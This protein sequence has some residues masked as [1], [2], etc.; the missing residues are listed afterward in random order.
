M[1]VSLF[2]AGALQRAL[3]AL[4]FAA[5]TVALTWPTALRPGAAVLG[6]ESADGMKHLWTLWW[7]RASVW[8]EGRFPFDTTLVN[9]P[10]GMGLY[11]IEPLNGIFAVLLPNV[12]IVL[13]SNLLVMVN[14]FATGMVGAWFGRVLTDG[15][16]WSGLA[17]GTVLLCSS[18]TTFFVA[19]GV[20]E[21]THLWWLPL[22]FGFLVRAVRGRAWKD[23]IILASVMVGAV[24]SCFYLGFFLAV[25]TILVCVWHLAVG[26]ER[27]DLLVRCATAGLLVLVITVP[28]GQTFAHSYARP[29]VQSGPPLEHV[30]VERGQQITDSLRSRL[31]PT[32]LW[33]PRRQA[34]DRHEI[35]YG[36]GRYLGILVSLLALIGVIRR[37]REALPWVIV[38]GVGILMALGSYLTI[39]GLEVAT[40]TGARIRLP[41]LWLNRLL[42]LVAEPVNFPVRFLAL[43]VMA[44]SALVALA[45][46]RWLALLIPLA[47]LEIAWAQMIPWPWP[48]FTLPDTSALAPLAK[49]PGRSV[50]DVTL[51]MQADASNRQLSLAGQMTHQHPT[52]VVPLERIEYFARDGYNHIRAM[53]LMH[54]I[55]GVYY[56][57]RMD[58]LTGEYRDD[59][60]MLD[61]LGYDYLLFATQRGSR[62]V[63][64]RARAA[65]NRLC[66][67][68]VVDGPGGVVW[69]VPPL[70]RR[71]LPK[72]ME[73]WRDTHLDRVQH[74]AKTGQQ[75]APAP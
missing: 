21:L 73:I 7:I 27:K 15:N 42:E 2:R 65:L 30:F 67:N 23:W 32:Q 1:A 18:V 70:R 35:G 28:I 14:L 44:Q 13:L 5:C 57:N 40:G 31:D 53:T 50:V 63:P 26:A 37:P 60:F 24:I 61:E 36:G 64:D 4:W 38:G 11:P 39:G 6:S 9:W 33:A 75:M 41:S 8:R 71:A 17:A 45:V 20:G 68:P 56:H 72:E 59:L 54:D 48:T 49:M 12:D 47:A 51:T 3:E 29:E 55:E 25:G 52:N 74:F 19:V 58:D 22:G 43:T 62:N 46:G 34:T 66:G 69:R 16:G 10:E